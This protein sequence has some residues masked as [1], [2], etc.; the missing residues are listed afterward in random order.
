MTAP[1]PRPSPTR[2]VR[3]RAARLR[4]GCAAGALGVLAAGPALADLSAQEVREAFES[5]YESFGYEVEIGAEET[6]DG[7]I[8]LSDVVLS[9]EVATPEGTDAEDGE[10]A[11]DGSAED[12]PEEDGS[13]DGA[14]AEAD[15][16]R[17]EATV[18]AMTFEEQ[19]EGGVLVT[20]AP[21]HPVTVRGTDPET[22][23]TYTVDLRLVTEGF[24]MTI[25]EAEGEAAAGAEA[26]W[27]Y[28]YQADRLGMEL[29][30]GVAA[31]EPIEGEGEVMVTS[32]SG[33]GAMPSDAG[34]AGEPRRYTESSRM[35]ELAVRG[36]F[37]VPE[38]EEDASGDASAAEEGKIAF[39][40]VV[41]DLAAS[42][43]VALPDEDDLAELMTQDDPQALFESGFAMDIALENEGTTFEF[44]ASGDAD[45]SGNLALE[46]GSESGRIRYAFDA[47]RMT[48]EGATEALRYVVSGDGMPMG[49]VEV[50][51]DESAGTF[52]FPVGVT[53]EPV[54]FTLRSNLSGLTLN[55]EV[56]TLFDPEARLPRDP[57]SL[58]LALEG[59]A[60][61]L[62]SLFDEEAQAEAEEAGEIPAEIEEASLDL[63]LDA[64][65]ATVEATGEFTFDNEDTTTF[66]GIPAPTGTI[67]IDASGI[68]ALL[69]TLVDMGLVAPDQLTPARLMLGL[70]ARSDEEGGYD[71]EIEVDGATGAITA[72]GQ[73]LR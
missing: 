27:R 7:T 9:F 28:D 66:P 47:E 19:P 13:E 44:A 41:S 58:L 69:D 32:L 67:V 33:S 24:A 60:R 20:L 70:F 48:I 5:Y 49:R 3:S 17:V 72:N 21:E 61:L 8:A 35:A 56:W 26:P 34:P 40:Y 23:E 65:G 1:A 73:R 15:D 57:A 36:S 59:R 25:A 71:S 53:E 22:G 42:I 4:A 63:D 11:E 50:A 39:S 55:E 46:G 18:D 62:A 2:P 37:P 16:V 43:D 51:L 31:G 45:P 6:S 52:D 64:V 14:G 68:D 12:E 30:D 10:P 54:P 38:E 29:V